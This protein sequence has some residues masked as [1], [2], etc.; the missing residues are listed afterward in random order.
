MN[1]RD[2]EMTVTVLQVVADYLDRAEGALI[3][4]MVDAPDARDL[5]ERAK[6]L[7]ETVLR[8]I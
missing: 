3:P 5:V 4:D 8:H 7:V 2:T 6:A 1:E